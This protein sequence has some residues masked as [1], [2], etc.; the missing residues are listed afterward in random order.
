MLRNMKIGPRLALGFGLLTLLILILGIFSLQKM[1]IMN[2]DNEA[3][4]H[5][6]LPSIEH[7]ATTNLSIMRYRIYAL[8]QI[9]RPEPETLMLTG[10]KL[11][12]LQVEINNHLK[13]Y[14]SLISTSEER[15]LF[16]RLTT[17]KESYIA[18]V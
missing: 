7:L 11:R 8:G 12:A 5:N 9:L 17:A 3:I 2:K 4:I 13:D 15:E 16:N 18:V 14:E 6:W 1:T 10:E